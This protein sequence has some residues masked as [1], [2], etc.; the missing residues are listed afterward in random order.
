MLQHFTAETPVT[1]IGAAVQ[2][3]GACIVD[4]LI[5]ED[6]CDRLMNDFLPHIDE[7][8]WCNTEPEGDAENQFFGLKTKRF[9]GLPSMS[10]R[11]QQ[12][13]CHPFLL[14]LAY[15]VLDGGGRCRD[16]R[17]STMEL[18]VLGK[19]EVRQMYHRDFDSWPYVERSASDPMLISANI[20]LC[21][22]TETNGATVV[23]PGSHLWPKGRQPEEGESCQAVMRKGSALIYSGDVIHG[24][25][26]NREDAIRT[27]FYIGYIP[28]WLNS[29][30][31]H[32]IS[33]PPDVVTSMNEKSQRLLGVSDGGF[34]VIP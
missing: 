33:N 2:K 22:F 7:A 17:V 14:S 30:E 12:I 28:S 26:S 32:L 6:L 3:A 34:Q 24:G 31:N 1:E 20:A 11:C 9:H 5:S 29:L 8:D 18:M 13:I 23:V 4:S 16:I 25:G 21:D 27:G 19:G 10:A 15:H